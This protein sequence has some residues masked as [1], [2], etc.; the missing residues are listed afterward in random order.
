MITKNSGRDE[1]LVPLLPVFPHFRKLSVPRH[2]VLKIQTDIF[3]KSRFVLSHR[4]LQGDH[5]RK[6]VKNSL[7]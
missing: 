7:R 1:M 6:G 3:D 4:R 5:R 2:W